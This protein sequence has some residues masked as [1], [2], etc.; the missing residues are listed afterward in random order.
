MIQSNPLNPKSSRYLIRL[1]PPKRGVRFF[2]FCLPAS[3]STSLNLTNS[4]GVLRLFFWPPPDRGTVRV[5]K[6]VEILA[7][8]ARYLSISRNHPNTLHS[9]TKVFQT[10]LV[11]T[12]EGLSERWY[13][14]GE[15]GFVRSED[16]WGKHTNTPRSKLTMPAVKCGQGG[17][18][19]SLNYNF[20][21]L[22]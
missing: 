5:Y 1:F 13:L 22:S 15:G 16:R 9:E 6:T 14:E 2:Y 3:Q 11:G 4:F 10:P 7:S 21:D 8:K 12:R 17:V 20:I 18:F 19:F